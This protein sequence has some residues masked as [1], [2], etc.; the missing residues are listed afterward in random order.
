MA[1]LSTFGIPPLGREA[2]RPV[3]RRFAQALGQRL[4]RP[5]LLE[6]APTSADLAAALADGR[7]DFGWL[8]P[9]EAWQLARSAGVEVVLQ[10]VRGDGGGYHAA[11]FSR[12]DGSVTSVAGL[13]GRNVAWVH[14]RSA[15]GYLV[16]AAHLREAG[17]ATRRPAYFAGSH[18]RVVQAVAA[19]RSVAGATF[20][21]VDPTT[22]QVTSA[23][24]T[25][26][27]PKSPTAFRVL[28]ALGPL[29]TDAICAWPGTGHS[30]QEQL[31]E[32]LQAMAEDDKDAVLLDT[33]FGTSR[34]V[35][36][37]LGAAQVLVRAMT[38]LQQPV[39]C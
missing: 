30:L 7:V 14:R 31:T 15:S 1:V 20:A 32:A 6:E 21:T 37:D 4:A 18:E 17:V 12:E 38:C 9:V 11:L 39:P 8:P 27:P 25:C 19:G 2:S 10:T 13:A 5:V 34:F 24:W 26:Y 35:P 36:P 3:T 16:P 22:G 23:G 28:I 33:I 29:P